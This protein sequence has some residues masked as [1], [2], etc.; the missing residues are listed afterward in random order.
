MRE[1]S[2]GD[3]NIEFPSPRASY[4]T[5]F[6]FVFAASIFGIDPQS[7]EPTPAQPQIKTI[8]DSEEIFLVGWCI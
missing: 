6:L 5:T 8:G 4:V 1:E 7:T 2:D 3:D